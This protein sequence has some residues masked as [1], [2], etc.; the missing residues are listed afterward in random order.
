[1]QLTNFEIIVDI[2]E[3]VLKS[4][5]FLG[6]SRMTSRPI[7]KRNPRSVDKWCENHGA[8]YEPIQTLKNVI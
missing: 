6:F 1:V 3:D 8:L 5:T 4:V 2:L 7:F